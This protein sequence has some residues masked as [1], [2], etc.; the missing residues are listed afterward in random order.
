MRNFGRTKVLGISGYSGMS[1]L[2]VQPGI[3]G[4][5]GLSKWHSV[6]YLSNGYVEDFE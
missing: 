3:S 5:S 2:D 4:Y 6:I 1:R